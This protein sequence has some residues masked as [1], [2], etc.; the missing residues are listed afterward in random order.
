MICS[1]WPI[2]ANATFGNCTSDAASSQLFGET[3][4][5]VT[6][7]VP[8]IQTLADMQKHWEA[9]YVAIAALIKQANIKIE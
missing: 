4:S 2:D 6:A 5:A 1:S 3:S 9:E 8:V 7:R